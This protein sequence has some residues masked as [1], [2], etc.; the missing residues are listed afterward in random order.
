MGEAIVQNSGPVLSS[1]HSLAQ[2]RHEPSAPVG[3]PSGPT[4]ISHP[5]DRRGYDLHGVHGDLVDHLLL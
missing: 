2:H 4:H 3:Q 5:T 1:S